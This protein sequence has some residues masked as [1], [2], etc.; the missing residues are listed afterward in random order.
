MHRVFEAVYMH[1]MN[2]KKNRYLS[3]P[4]EENTSSLIYLNDYLTS[5]FDLKIQACYD[6]LVGVL[7]N[8]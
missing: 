5:S 1:R 6:K 4:Y 7:L 2:W 8:S 3:K